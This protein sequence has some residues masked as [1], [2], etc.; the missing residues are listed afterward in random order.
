[1]SDDGTG[2]SAPEKPTPKHGPPVA[3]ILTGALIFQIGIG[4][5]L[6]LGDVNASGLRLPGTSPDAP[7]LTE[8]VRPGDQRRLFRPDRDRP[9]TRPARDPGELPER[10]VLTQEDGTTYRLEGGIAE[11]DAARII[12]RLEDSTPAPETLILQSP[13]GTVTE[14]LALGRHFRETGL[15][16]RMLS[17]E[18]CFSACPYM[19]AG[20]ASRDIDDAAQVGVHQHYF[21]ESTILPASFAV[22]DIQAGQG[23]VMTYLDEMGID[24]MVMTHALATPPDEIYVLLPD[25]LRDYGFISD[26]SQ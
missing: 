5:M 7:R 26:A 2:K 17:G 21:G 19:L 10:L 23:E 14:A 12:K 18:Y 24:P 22:E 4:A 13:G 15:T 8:P 11:G 9:A 16:T 20:G 1:M 3:R 6:V 25:Q